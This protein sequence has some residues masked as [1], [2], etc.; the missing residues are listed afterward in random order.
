MI[1]IYQ[2][3]DNENKI[4]VK[5]FNS[6]TKYIL[7]FDISNYTNLQNFWFTLSNQND[8]GVVIGEDGPNS[9]NPNRN[10]HGNNNHAKSLDNQATTIFYYPQQSSVTYDLDSTSNASYNSDASQNICYLHFYGATANYSLIQKISTVYISV[11]TNNWGVVG[12]FNS[13]GDN[14]GNDIPMTSDGNQIYTVIIPENH[15]N[16][17]KF[18]YNS[19]WDVN[20]GGQNNILVTSSDTNLSLPDSSKSYTV[21][22]NLNEMSYSI[23]EYKITCFKEGTNI[24]CLVDNKELYIP[25]ENIRKGTLVKT[26]LYGYLPVYM[27]G[28]SKIYNSG[29]NLHSKNRLYICKKE[30]Y[31]DLNEDLIITGCHS[32]LVDQLS[33][34][35]IY[36]TVE[37]FGVIYM[38]D[39]HFRLIACL[40][41]RAEPYDKEG[42]YEIWHLALENEDNYKNYG[43]YANGLL[44][45][46]ISKR[47][48]KD[49]SGMS[50]V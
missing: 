12:E 19:N 36:K 10:W 18:R 4:Q 17:F 28:K 40:D 16:Y 45:E 3:L 39:N 2:V 35:E 30:K 1:V 47:M 23:V 27:I 37:L 43:I 50:E 31:K 42:I 38:T 44:V 41:K 24:L 33:I 8:G 21:T 25:I 14:N 13:W 15:G 7:S 34:E 9:T 5:N 22:M 32:I 20:Y 6:L 49:L 26:V 46:S 48:L 11:P 29:D